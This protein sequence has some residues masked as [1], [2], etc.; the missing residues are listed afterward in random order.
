MTISQTPLLTEIAAGHQGPP[1]PSHVRAYFAQRLRL[2]LFN[3]LLDKFVIAQ[4]DGLTKASLARRIEKTPDLINRWLGASSNLTLDTI[5][6][7]LLGIAAEELLPEATSPLEQTRNN[8]SHFNELQNAD[9]TKNRAETTSAENSINTTP[10]N[11]DSGRALSASIHAL[12]S[13]MKKIAA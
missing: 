12:D 8:Y 4:K 10:W 5:S 3:F 2:R 11:N 7:L 6:D 9:L 13:H 1:I